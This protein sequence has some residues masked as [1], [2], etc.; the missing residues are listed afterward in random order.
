MTAP[1]PAPR[2]L[3]SFDDLR[4][5]WLDD[6]DRERLLAEQRECTLAWAAPDGWPTAVTTRYVWRDRLF[7]MTATEHRPRCDA[8]R[9]DERVS[10]VVSS[11]GT[12][13]GPM[14][15]VT[16]K[17]RCQVLDRSRIPGWFY[18]EWAARHPHVPSDPA[19]R[20]SYL[21]RLDSVSRV[22][23]VV[24]PERWTCFDGQKMMDATGGAMQR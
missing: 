21:A 5:Y 24:T 1:G 20:A 23:L 17:G 16:A 3:E 6:A 18:E 13:L 12:P 19:A 15:S 11:A 22:V 8:I 14:R 9:R 10:V 2:R 7:W 4:P